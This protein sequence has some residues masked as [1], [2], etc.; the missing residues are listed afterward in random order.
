M[1]QLLSILFLETWYQVMY[2]SDPS[3]LPLLS[4][5]FLL[6]CSWPCNP[7]HSIVPP[8][9]IS[10]PFFCEPTELVKPAENSPLCSPGF[11]DMIAS[12]RICQAPEE[13]RWLEWEG[14]PSSDGTVTT[15]DPLSWH[16]PFKQ[17]D[18]FSRALNHVPTF[19]LVLF[20]TKATVLKHTRT[21]ES[22]LPAGLSSVLLTPVVVSL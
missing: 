20:R 11:M 6:P 21:F 1:S 8:L 19:K 2:R 16:W 12:W 9:P 4:S 5:L 3:S 17:Q 10:T 14:F 15:A 18:P 22:F 7:G 13:D